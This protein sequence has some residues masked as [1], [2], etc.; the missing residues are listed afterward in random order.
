MDALSDPIL[1][2]SITY[3]LL[4][5]VTFSRQIF[6]LYFE[7]EKFGGEKMALQMNEVQSISNWEKFSFC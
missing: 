6:L 4:C 1:D 5:K 7:K 2:Q 3:N